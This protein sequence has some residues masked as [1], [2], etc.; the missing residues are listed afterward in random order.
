MTVDY[1]FFCIKKIILLY[2]Q[3]RR[4][5]A[6]VPR[7]ETNRVSQLRG[8]WS[9]LFQQ[10]HDLRVSLLRD[11]RS[12]FEQELDKQTKA[13]VLEV[14]QFRNRFDAHG[15]GVSGID[16]VEATRRLE[17]FKGLFKAYDA[18]KQVLES[19]AMLFGIPKKEFAEL[20]K[21]KEELDL[22]T[23]LYSVYEEYINFNE[24]FRQTLWVDLD[25]EFATTRV[26]SIWK[27]VSELRPEVQQWEACSHLKESITFYLNVLPLIEKLSRKVCTLYIFVVSI[28]YC[29]KFGVIYHREVLKMT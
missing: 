23:E 17:E 2:F 7:E 5:D 29:C 6:A 15:P 20:T 1:S 24:T 22:L 10:L 13:F 25:Y 14:I 26:N 16:P 8:R 28:S 18:K 19:V 11:R 12:G 3:Y 21:L 9:E 27:S 4:S